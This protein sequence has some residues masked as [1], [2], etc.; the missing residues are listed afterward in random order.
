MRNLRKIKQPLQKRNR[1]S[2]Y[3]DWCSRN[4]I[5]MVV[6]PILCGLLFALLCLCIGGAIAGWHILRA[7]TSKTAIL[8]YVLLILVAIYTAFTIFKKYDRR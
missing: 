1:Y 8:I 3:K 4:R 7:L 2:D 5:P 6:F